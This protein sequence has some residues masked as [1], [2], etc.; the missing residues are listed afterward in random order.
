MNP[1]AN[2]VLGRKSNGGIYQIGV[3]GMEAGSNIG[4][5]DLRHQFGVV[6]LAQSPLTE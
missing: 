2:S 6:G 5:T 1:D 4:R 3:A